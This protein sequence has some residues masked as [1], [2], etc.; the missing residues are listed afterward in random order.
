MSTVHPNVLSP[1]WSC[2]Q[3]PFVCYLAY[4]PFRTQSLMSC[5]PDNQPKEGCTDVANCFIQFPW[6]R[7]VYPNLLHALAT[8]CWLQAID[9]IQSVQKQQHAESLASIQKAEQ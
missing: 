5:G 3:Q 4:T 2:S 6:L 9:V 7:T 8:F 1:V